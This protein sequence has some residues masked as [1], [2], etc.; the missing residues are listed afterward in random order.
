M[1]T[2]NIEL[3]EWNQQEVYEVNEWVLNES[4]D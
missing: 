1:K 2:M 3:N 4:I